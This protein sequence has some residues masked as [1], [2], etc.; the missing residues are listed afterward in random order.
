MDVLSMNE[1]ERSMM[2]ELL[3]FYNPTYERPEALEVYCRGFHMLYGRY[4][5]AWEKLK[6]QGFARDAKGNQ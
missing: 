3:A 5:P 4:P 6:A 2:N 1:A